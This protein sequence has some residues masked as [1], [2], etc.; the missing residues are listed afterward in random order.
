MKNKISEFNNN[1]KNFIKNIYFLDYNLIYKCF[2]YKIFKF[3][4]LFRWKLV[5][6]IKPIFLS[7][8][9]IDN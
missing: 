7:Y 9:N 2:I 1:I 5:S 6:F 8:L 4:Y 3:N